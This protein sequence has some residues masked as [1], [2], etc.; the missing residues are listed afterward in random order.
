MTCRAVE[1]DHLTDECTTVYADARSLGVSELTEDR[2]PNDTMPE[3]VDCG[4][5]AESLTCA[6]DAETSLPGRDGATALILIGLI[7]HVPLVGGL[8]TRLNA[9]V[10]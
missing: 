2:V 3:C 4:K 5:T 1:Y 6:D 10:P 8:T 9:K 7:V